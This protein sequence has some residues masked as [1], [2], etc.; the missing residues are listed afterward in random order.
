MH[1]QGVDVRHGQRD[2]D[3]RGSPRPVRQSFQ[4]HSLIPDGTARQRREDEMYLIAGVHD[5]FPLPRQVVPALPGVPHSKI[6]AASRVEHQHADI[7]G[8]A[9]L[10]QKEI[11]ILNAPVVPLQQRRPGR[12]LAVEIIAE[13][14]PPV[15]GKVGKRLLHPLVRKALPDQKHRGDLPLR[16]RTP[17]YL[18]K[19]RIPLL[20]RRHA[21]RHLRR[22]VR[23]C[24]D[25][26]GLCAAV[27]AHADE[28]HGTLSVP[29]AQQHI[30]LMQ[31]RVLTQQEGIERALMVLPVKA[32]E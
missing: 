27:V 25:N 17:A 12:A 32:I 13:K 6:P 14:H 28:L 11:L 16:R 2:P 21:R 26:R 19:R 9:V 15:I 20:L 29:L 22:R 4:R 18:K 8:Q 31:R 3:P 23:P 1:A 30:A 24:I 5:E 7:A 10:S